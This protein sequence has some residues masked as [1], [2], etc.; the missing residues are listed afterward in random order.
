MSGANNVGTLLLALSGAARSN[1]VINAGYTCYQTMHT[2]YD[3]VFHRR[4]FVVSSIC[5]F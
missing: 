5:T 1:G 2:A 4:S 3:A